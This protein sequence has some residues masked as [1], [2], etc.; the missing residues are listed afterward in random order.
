MTTEARKDLDLQTLDTSDVDRWIGRP[1]GGGQLK[2]PIAPNDIRRWAQGMQNANPLYYDEKFAAESALGRFV[3]P[4]SFTICCDVGHGATPAIQGT[5]PGTH[6]LFGGDEWWFFGPRVEPGDHLHSE[7]F[8]YDYRVADT[9]FAGQTMFQRGDTTY[10]NQRGQLIARQRSTSIR[11]LVENARKLDSLKELAQEPEWTDEDLE[12]IEREILA[13]FEPLQGHVRRSIE[14]VAVGD[15]L[16]QRP[17]G[18]HTVQT[19][20]TEWRAYTMTIW[21]ASAL[22]GYPTS[23]GRAGWIREMTRNE[24]RARVDPSRGDGLYYGASRGHVQERYAKLIGVPRAYGY[25]AS[26]GAWVMDYLGNWAGETGFVE[27]S[28]IQYRHPPLAGDLTLMNGKVV[29]KQQDPDGRG[30][31]A[32]VQVTMSTQAGTIMARGNAEV[33]L[34]AEG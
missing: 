24:D 4:Q 26:M 16:P 11:Y 12:R 21:G 33:R 19:F 14:Q 27:H 3:A 13:Y 30:G 22:D 6:M 10:I 2:D 32:T 31:I 9:S 20:T 7:R 34:P 25:G 23:T 28:R 17:I 15:D 5:M 1:I 8:A 29:E 18:P